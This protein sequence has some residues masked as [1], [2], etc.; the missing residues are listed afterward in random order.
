[1]NETT[2]TQLKVIVERAV[3]PIRAGLRRKQRMREELLAH[4]TAV[5]GEELARIGDEATALAR[6]AERFGDPAE[7][8][9][10]LQSSVPARDG[11]D[12]LMDQL[13]Y[14]PGEP[15]LRRA[16]RHAAILEATVFAILAMV[17]AAVSATRLG[18]QPPS[19]WP[20]IQ[21]IL[22]SSLVV[23]AS[24]LFVL[25]FTYLAD[26]LR[27]AL[28]GAD[29]RSGFKAIMVAI[30]SGLLIPGLGFAL[31]LDAAGPSGNDLWVVIALG[32]LVP[33]ALLQVA[34]VLGARLRHHQEWSSLAIE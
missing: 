11:I 15:T 23:L 8:V 18:S 32:L 31:W 14:R 5:F 7:L 27:A 26:W 34:K 12:R 10:P 22:S 24:F 20:G 21:L 28:Y 4:V 13:W 29:G 19:E 17:A 30:A 6:T 2:L 33:G 25:S 1:M 3:R 9:A 16:V